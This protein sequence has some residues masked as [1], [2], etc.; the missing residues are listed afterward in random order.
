MNTEM[1]PSQCHIKT[2]SFHMKFVSTDSKLLIEGAS[3][4]G[5]V[6]DS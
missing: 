1:F 3:L 5:M 6:K 4:S 2:G